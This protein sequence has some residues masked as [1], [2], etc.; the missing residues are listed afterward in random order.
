MT[1]ATVKTRKSG[2]RP[3]GSWLRTNARAAVLAL[4]ALRQTRLGWLLPLMI[5]L[6]LFALLS[7]LLGAAGPLAPFVYPLL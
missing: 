5:I 7:F 2:T 6:F 4:K 3:R 1:T